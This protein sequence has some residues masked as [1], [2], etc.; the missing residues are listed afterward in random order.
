MQ[1]LKRNGRLWQRNGWLWRLIVGLTILAV[2]AI[3]WGCQSDH[4]RSAAD[5]APDA[6]T[7]ERP[8]PSAAPRSPAEAAVLEVQ[9][10]LE[11]MQ[12]DPAQAAVPLRPAEFFAK[13]L[14]PRLEKLGAEALVLLPDGVVLYSANPEWIGRNLVTDPA[15][16]AHPET[17]NSVPF[18]GLTISGRL[19]RPFPVR[20][21]A[22]LSPRLYEWWTVG[23]RGA[24]WRVGALRPAMAKEERK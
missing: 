24:E 4:R 21:A 17:R 16:L 1:E 23:V 13:E 14:E 20:G 9:H 12:R 15:T 19:T 8:A 5:R 10:M 18:I 6:A 22:G 3:G 7:G 2:A 11:A